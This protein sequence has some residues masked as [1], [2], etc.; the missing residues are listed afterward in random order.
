MPKQIKI[1]IGEDEKALSRAL[2]LKLT[3]SGFTVTVAS[4]GELAL[5]AIKKDTFDMILLDMVMPKKD[6]FTVLKE[7]QALG[8][9]TPVVV[10]SNLGQKEDIAKAKEL[11]AKDFFVKSNMPLADIVNYI[12]KE[13]G[14]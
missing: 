8:I 9:K 13:L 3:N 14:I 6:G 10:L 4:D 1:L 7:M 12:K 2:E 11:G 5:D